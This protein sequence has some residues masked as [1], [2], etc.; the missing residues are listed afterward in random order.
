MS[1]SSTYFAAG[2][3]IMKQFVPPEVK[4]GDLMRNAGPHF[5]IT[6]TNG[7]PVPAP[8]RTRSCRVG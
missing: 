6:F 1:G 5:P 8:A 4:D 7:K 2:N 3:H